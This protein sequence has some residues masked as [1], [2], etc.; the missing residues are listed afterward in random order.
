M[1]EQADGSSSAAQRAQPNEPGTSPTRPQEHKPASFLDWVLRRR[2]R[3]GPDTGDRPITEHE[4]ATAAGQR[5]MLVN[6]R[7]MRD[8]R[9]EDVAIPRAD[10][11]AVPSDIAR[12]DLKQVFKDSG[13]SR[14]PVF[15]DTLD[16]A[17]GLIHLKDVA[18]SDGFIGDGDEF[19]L[20]PFI[21]PLIFAPPSMPI[22]VLLQ[23]M[24]SERMHMALVID[25]YGGADGLVTMEDLVEQI[26]GEIADEHDSDED[27]MWVAEGDG[28]YRALARAD[29]EDFEAA[30]K[31]DLLPD[32]LDEDVD[33]LGG[34]VSMLAGRVPARGEVVR[35]PQGHEFEVLDADPRRIKRLRIRVK[36]HAVRDRAAE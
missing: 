24:Q 5:Q 34:L 26:V 8:M 4:R 30:A 35:H 17:L 6:L 10:I 21:R 32:D 36:G 13:F 20:S 28:V 1:G 19:D 9:I 18:L 25:E 7:N 14:I 2:G 33:T 23:K 12:D 29:L 15:A 3:R 22:G 27:T 11:I 31:V 16:N